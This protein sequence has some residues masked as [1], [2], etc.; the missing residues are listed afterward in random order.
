MRRNSWWRA[1]AAAVVMVV[2]ASCSRGGQ[3]LPYAYFR[4]TLPEQ[5]YVAV[6]SM[7]SYS[8]E[9][10]SI[11]TIGTTDERMATDA[12]HWL[13]IVYPTLNAKIHLSYK[14]I[15]PAMFRTVSEECRDLAYKHTIRADA[16][17]EDYYA[18]TIE[19]VYG[20]YYE[21]EGDAASQAQFFMTDSVSHFLRG[22]LYFNHTPNA[23]SI[24]PVAQYIRQDMV[25]LIESIRWKD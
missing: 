2:A 3:P 11:C 21:M 9:I 14:A 12:D 4:I 1:M 17:T 7:G 16:I 13:D 6:D 25:H 22:S 18:D 8:T 20:I 15:T 10:N 5:T 24:A 23:D 19:H